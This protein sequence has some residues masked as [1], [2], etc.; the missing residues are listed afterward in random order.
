MYSRRPRIKPQGEQHPQGESQV[1]EADLIEEIVEAELPDESLDGS[2]VD[3]P[4]A[5]RKGK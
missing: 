4:I 3:L 1:I 5:L 2:T